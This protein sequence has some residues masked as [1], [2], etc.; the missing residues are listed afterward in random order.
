MGG[1]RGAVVCGWSIGGV[2]DG[3]VDARTVSGNGGGVIYVD[4]KRV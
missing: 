4:E 2:G 1:L 3:G